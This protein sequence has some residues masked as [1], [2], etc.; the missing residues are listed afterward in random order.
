MQIGCTP[1]EESVLTVRSE[2]EGNEGVPVENLY[3]NKALDNGVKE[4]VINFFHIWSD[5]I[6][7]KGKRPGLNMLEQCE[8]VANTRYLQLRF[9]KNF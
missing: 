8:V 4:N 2:D 9:V 1:D 5:Y 3:E 7:S 6:G